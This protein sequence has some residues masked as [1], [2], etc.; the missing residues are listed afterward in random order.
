M[1]QN[2]RRNRDRLRQDPA[3]ST[4]NSLDNSSQ[5]PILSITDAISNT[6]MANYV[7]SLP[8][9][10]L[11][12]LYDLI[13]AELPKT[14]TELVK[15]IQSPQFLQS[16]SSF[17]SVLSQP[18]AGSVVASQLGYSYQGEGV[19]GFLDGVR[20]ASKSDQSSR[21]HNNSDK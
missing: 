12:P 15:I 16:L 3:S 8:D 4:T 14:R 20:H 11:T 5:V 7:S 17:D 19:Q 10:A 1:I 2:V 9:H 6:D 13:P 21:D 18:G